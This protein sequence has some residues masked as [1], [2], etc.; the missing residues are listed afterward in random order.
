MLIID[1]I[2]QDAFPQGDLA[3]NQLKFLAFFLSPNHG[4]LTYITK[5]N[6]IQIGEER[7]FF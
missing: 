2:R 6:L 3:F 1:L 5:E 7:P 4:S